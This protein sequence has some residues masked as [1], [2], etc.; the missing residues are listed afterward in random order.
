MTQLLHIMEDLSLLVENGCDIDVIYFDFR[1]AFDQL[2]HQR[3]LSKLASYEYQEILLNGLQIF[4]Q[5][6]V[7]KIESGIAVLV[8]LM[9]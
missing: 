3:L 5:I 7:R 8:R 2:P 1:K 4:Y 6:G 9:Y